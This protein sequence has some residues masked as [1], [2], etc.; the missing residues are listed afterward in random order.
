MDLRRLRR[1]ALDAV[2]GVLNASTIQ[3][4]RYPSSRSS[5]RI[6]HTLKTPYR[7]GIARVTFEPVD[8]STRL[9]ALVPKPSTIIVGRPAV[10]VGSEED[11]LTNSRANNA[12]PLVG[13]R[14]RN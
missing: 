2:L 12:A 7:D 13:E 3:N 6:L 8:F 1:A 11:H 10:K 4:A 9:A 14:C 5:V